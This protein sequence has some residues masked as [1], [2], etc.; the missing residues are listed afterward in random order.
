MAG[1][2][3][4]YLLFSVFH[5]TP[6]VDEDIHQKAISRLLRGQFDTP[7]LPMLP[8]YHWIVASISALPGP[9]LNL[10]NVSSG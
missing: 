6:L 7:D 5:P 10:S 3:L 4:W 9:S 2:L 1:Y 8:G